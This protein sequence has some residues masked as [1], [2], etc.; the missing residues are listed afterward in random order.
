MSIIGTNG[1]KT[2]NSI[3]LEF[4]SQRMRL[5]VNPEHLSIKRDSDN[6]TVDIVRLGEI[7]RF[8]FRKLQQC[9]IDSFFPGR[10][11]HWFLHGQNVLQPSAYISFLEN[12]RLQQRPCRLVITNAG[13]GAKINMLVSIESLDIKLR[14]GE[15]DVYFK[16]DLKEYRPHA[17]R[18]VRINIAQAPPRRQPPATRPP[19]P[20]QSVTIGSRVIVNGRLHRDSLG[21]GPGQTEQNAVRRVS[22]IARGARF[23]YHVK[24]LDGGWRGWVTASS[25]RLQS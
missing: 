11:N 10:S 20:N 6:R 1:R 18:E 12:I 5:P 3:Y 8:G 19:S 4:S 21:S 7:N 22:H 16:L 15:G 17:A 25:V 2:T 14:G 9:T 13:G 23:P 24:T